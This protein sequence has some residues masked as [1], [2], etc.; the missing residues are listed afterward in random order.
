M[1]TPIILWPSEELQSTGFANLLLSFPLPLLT[2]C[3]FPLKN[4]FLTLYCYAVWV[5]FTLPFTQ[6]VG[7]WLDSVSK[8]LSHVTEIGSEVQALPCMG[9]SLLQSLVPFDPHGINAGLLYESWRKEY[10]FV[11]FPLNE[12]VCKYEVWKAEPIFLPRRSAS[13]YSCRNQ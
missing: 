8:I 11:F 1:S 5:D 3:R 10:L 4:H 6:G 13:R 12:V 2:A 7:S 9:T